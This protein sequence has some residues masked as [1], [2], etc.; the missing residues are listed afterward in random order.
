MLRPW[1]YP[2]RIPSSVCV[3]SAPLSVSLFAY[4]WSVFVLMW[5]WLWLIFTPVWNQL[6]TSSS[7][8]TCLPSACNIST[9]S[10]QPLLARLLFI[11][12]VHTSR[13]KLVHTLSHSIL[14][15]PVFNCSLF[16]SQDQHSS[17][18]TS[19]HLPTWQNLQAFTPSLP[20]TIPLLSPSSRPATLHH[21]LALPA[22]SGTHTPPSSPHPHSQLQ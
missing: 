16:V 9:P 14:C 2:L 21:H 20:A 8:H 22:A 4:V 7:L 13:P 3:P 12:A 19:A 18:K 10:L 6:I 1:L 15:F 17:V 11:S 5:G